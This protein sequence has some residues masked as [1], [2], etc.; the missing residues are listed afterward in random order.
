MAVPGEQGRQ[1][2][3]AEQLS[4]ARSGEALH[5]CG[6]GA[7][8]TA[9]LA[10]HL[11]DLLA[12]RGWGAGAAA[13][14][15]RGNHQAALLESHSGR[16]EGSRGAPRRGAVR[17]EEAGRDTSPKAASVGESAG[18]VDGEKRKRKRSKSFRMWYARAG[19]NHRPFAPE[20]KH[21][22]VCCSFYARPMTVMN[23]D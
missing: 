8:R 20:A 19:S 17:V 16:A 14:F 11:C 22:C 2:A 6:G 7:N 9:P 15:Q 13:P 1:S 21:R 5:G 4:E 23:A 3:A 18:E 10:A 12:G